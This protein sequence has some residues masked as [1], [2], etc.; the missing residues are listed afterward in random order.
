MLDERPTITP[1]DSRTPVVRLTANRSGTDYLVG[2]IHGTY[3]ALEQALKAVS[4]DKS[5]DRLISVGDLVDRGDESER[6]LEFVSEPWFFACLGNHDAPYAFP[7]GEFYGRKLTCQPRDGWIDQLSPDQAARITAC[8]SALP[9]AI[10]VETANGLVG[11]VHAEVP[12]RYRSWAEF[13][14]ALRAQDRDACHDA[15]WRRELARKAGMITANERYMGKARP[16]ES[17]LCLPDVAYTV[18]GHTPAKLLKC[19]PYRI[20]NRHYI[21]TGAGIAGLGAPAES[22][23]CLFRADDPGTVV[24]RQRIIS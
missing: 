10:E 14:Q 5:R 6:V 2:D 7:D 8:L 12:L 1:F 20:A 21:D 23:L 9:W 15:I 4:F 19:E 16:D 3:S 17:D 13:A 22:G 18:H 11:V 24:H